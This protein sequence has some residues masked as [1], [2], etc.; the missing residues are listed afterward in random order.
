MTENFQNLPPSSGNFDIPLFQKVYDFYKEL[1]SAQIN[2]PKVHKHTL[3]QR[4]DNTTLDL[5]ELLILASRRQSERHILLD[6]A[7]AKLNSLKLLLRL[8][9]DVKCIDDNKYLQLESTLQEIGKILGGWI[10]HTKQN[11]SI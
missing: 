6:K 7:N 4:L 5:F 1:Y 9:K 11:T 3:G 10:K 2:L 8:A